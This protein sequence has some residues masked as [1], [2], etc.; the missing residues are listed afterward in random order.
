MTK[1][2]STIKQLFSTIAAASIVT[3]MSGC[4]GGDSPS[5]TT[6]ST[7]LSGTFVDAPVAGLDYNC[8]SGLHGKTDTAGTFSYKAGDT[9]E[10]KIGSLSLGSVLIT[11]V[12]TPY[13]LADGN[14]TIAGNIA[15]LLQ[16]LDGDADASK[17]SI[18]SDHN[19]TVGSFDFRSTTFDTTLGSYATAHSLTHVHPAEALEAMNGYLFASFSDKAYTMTTSQGSMQMEFYK[20][21]QFV[22]TYSD[23]EINSGSWTSQN[24][25][26]AT[27]T[28]QDYYKMTVTILSSTSASIKYETENEPAITASYTVQNTASSIW[29]DPRNT[30]SEVF[31][32]LNITNLNNNDGALTRWDYGTLIPVKLNGSAVAEEA[33]NRIEAVLGRVIFDRTSIANTPEGDITRGITVSEMTTSLIN[34]GAPWAGPDWRPCGEQTGSM[35]GK[36]HLDI[37]SAQCL[38]STDIAIHEFAHALGMGGIHYEGYGVG[39]AIGGGFWSVLK[40]MYSNAIGSTKANISVYWGISENNTTGATTAASGL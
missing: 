21:G 34:P 12:T 36:Q 18:S 39:P 26:T 23:G 29:N 35:N 17:I 40:T 28:F 11:G 19:L 8:T 5:T 20:N 32:D 4:G 13:M 7:T 33:I 24:G 38:P 9:C 25:T 16:T 30:A 14:T 2:V 6:T 15:A 3:L 37:G 31:K 1:N 10:F 22:Q 27:I